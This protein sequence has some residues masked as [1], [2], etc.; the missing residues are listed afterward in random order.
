M[1]DAV[2]TM[3]ASGYPFGRLGCFLS[4]DG[5]YGLPCRPGDLDATLCMPFPNGIVPIDVPVLPTPLYEAGANFLLFGLPW[6]LR[7]RVR[8]GVLFAL[9]LAGSGVLRFLV[10]FIRRPDVRP[11]RVFGLR[12]AHLIAAGQVLFGLV[13]LVV[14]LLASRRRDARRAVL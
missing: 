7:T 6:R 9:Y 3:L 4:G 14:V 13:L 12:A 11:D 10:E 8:P 1:T 2:A 5:C